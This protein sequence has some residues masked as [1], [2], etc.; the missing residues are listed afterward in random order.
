MTERPAD[1]ESPVVVPEAE[2]PE[3]ILVPLMAHTMPSA[4]WP[5]H[6]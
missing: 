3:R 4:L 1:W 6:G 5:G 2:V